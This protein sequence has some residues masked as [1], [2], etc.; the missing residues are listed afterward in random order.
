MRPRPTPFLVSI[1]DRAGS[2]NSGWD[3]SVY[4]PAGNLV[5]AAN[6]VGANGQAIAVT[7]VAAGTYRVFVTFTYLYDAAP[8]VPRR[9]AADGRH[10]DGRRRQAH[11]G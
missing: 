10:R 1:K 4:D 6:G 3:L 7:A 11:A 9:G 8:G 2:Q 5:G